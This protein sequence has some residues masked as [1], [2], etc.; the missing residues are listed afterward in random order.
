MPARNA[1]L[2]VYFPVGLHL[3]G[4]VIA[5]RV[6]KSI[7]DG[8]D[9]LIGIVAVCTLRT[10]GITDGVVALLWEIGNP[11]LLVAVGSACMDAA[12]LFVVFPTECV[13]ITIGLLHHPVILI[14]DSCRL[15][16]SIG[17]AYHV[18]LS[19]IGIANKLLGTSVRHPQVEALNESRIRMS[20]CDPATAGI[21]ECRKH[22]ILIG[23][24]DAP[25]IQVGNRGKTT[26]GISPVLSGNGEVE[27]QVAVVFKCNVPFLRSGKGDALEAVI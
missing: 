2:G 26:D 25:A 27:G 6:A 13:P 16:Q 14:A 4:I 18:A 22:A 20:D 19:V 24:A 23:K 11:A 17:N 3:L 9:K 8:A 1:P 21:G 12:S 15:P 5:G 10:T 7:G